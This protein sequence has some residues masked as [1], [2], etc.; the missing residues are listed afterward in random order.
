MPLSKQQYEQALAEATG[1]P[2]VLTDQDYQRLL[3]GQKLSEK[4]LTA[5]K[6]RGANDADHEVEPDTTGLLEPDKPA[7][8]YAQQSPG[9]VAKGPVAPASSSIGRIP[10][11]VQPSAEPAGYPP[12]GVDSMSPGALTV[13][14]WAQSAPSP[15]YGSA[16]LP[17]EVGP[18]GGLGLD[19]PDVI[20]AKAPK[21]VPAEGGMV[22]APDVVRASPT[23]QQVANA[24]MAFA[25]RND[26]RK[27]G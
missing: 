7:A 8:I 15:D 26:A 12:L 5:A 14:K 19:K 11:G 24:Q 20:T 4:A 22:F 2:V 13:P 25:R 9:Y 3:K 23:P 17:Y 27:K 1:G 16:A 21:P 10:Y 6:A 18:L